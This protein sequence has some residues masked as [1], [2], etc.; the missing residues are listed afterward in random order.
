MDPERQAFLDTLVP[1]CPN[2]KEIWHPLD[3]EY[4]KEYPAPV[5]ENAQRMHYTNLNST[6]TFFGPMLYYFARAI[7]AEHILEIG[8]AEGYTSFYLANAA[9][10]NGTRYGMAGNMYYG[11]EILGKALDIKEQ[12]DKL[13]LPND[14]RVMSSAD[15]TPETFDNVTFDII[16]QDGNHERDYV[17]KEVETLY[18]QLKG[19]GKGFLICHD[20][21]GPAEDGVHEIINDP[22]YN[23]EYIRICEIYGIAIL[24]KMDGY[25]E[26]KRWTN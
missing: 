1:Y 18:P 24:R 23:W 14:I 21:Y 8:M 11:V 3:I 5:M 22:R 26:G 10:D 2:K 13:E 4:F 16:F 20:V 15:I 17:V 12:M 25:K 19:E 9:K 6:I 7:G